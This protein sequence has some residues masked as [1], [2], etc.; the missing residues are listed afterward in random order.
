[1]EFKRQGHCVYYAKYHIVISTKYRR[2]IFRGGMGEYL[3]EVVL[4]IQK[5]K[6]EIVI[7]EVNTDED[8]IHVLVSIPPKYPVSH[9]VN[10][11]KSNTGRKMR[12]KFKFL[13]KVY[14]GSEG[15]WSIGY[16]V[17]TVGINEETIRKYI[18]YQGREDSGQAKL[19][20]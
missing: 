16:F 5:H 9:V 11:L 8:H 2:K 1:M 10:L 13:D 12:E 14:W 3:K 6:P 18:E 17:S 19:E 20:F 7:E 15:I 4:D